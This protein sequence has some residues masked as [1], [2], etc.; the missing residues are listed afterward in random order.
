MMFLYF[1]E[2]LHAS[3]L[4]CGISVVITVSFEIPLFAFSTTAL[5]RVGV[6]RLLT[7]SMVCYIARVFIYTLVPPDHPEY[8]LF[9]EPTHG[10]TYSCFTMASVQFIALQSPVGLENSAQTLLGLVRS[11]GSIAGTAGAGFLMAVY[12]PVFT[13]RTFAVLVTVALAVWLGTACMCPSPSSTP[14]AAPAGVREVG[15]YKRVSQ[16]STHGPDEHGLNEGDD[17]VEM[18]LL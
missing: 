11:V 17:V 16:A 10:I 7:I 14:A 5:E 1:R 6:D 12:G 2:H 15:G 18:Q 13:Y 8:L 4:L 3:N 9:V